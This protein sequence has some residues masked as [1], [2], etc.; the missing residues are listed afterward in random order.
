MRK[1]LLLAL[2]FL[3]GL[4]VTY[5]LVVAGLLWHMQLN[6]IVDRDGGMTM[7]I[8]FVIGPI[9]A[10]H[11]GVIA[12]LVL[13]IWLRRSNRWPPGQRTARE[14][15]WP[16]GKRAAFAAVVSGIVV[17]TLASAAI[18]VPGFTFSTYQAALLA[19]LSPYAFALAAAGI[20]AL[21]VLRRAGRDNAQDR[22]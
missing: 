19:S 4:I 8:L 1:A 3:G 18:Q 13:P 12:A 2:F 9:A 11:G 21:L 15:R 22:R 16:P 6:G 5:V 14:P 20:A 10:L 17:F 7:G